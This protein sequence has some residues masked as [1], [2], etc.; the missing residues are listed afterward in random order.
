MTTSSRRRRRAAARFGSPSCSRPGRTRSSSTASCSRAGPA[1]PGRRCREARRRGCR[2]PR[3]RAPRAPRS[4]TARRRRP[5]ARRATSTSPWSRSRTPERIRTFAGERGWGHLRLL[6]SRNNTY[7]RDYNAETPDGEQAPIL[8]VFVRD[9]DE[10]RHSW[11]SEL[12]FAPRDGGRG[13]AARR[14]DLAGLERPRRDPWRPRHPLHH[15]LAD[16]HFGGARTVGG[17]SPTPIAR[18]S[19]VLGLEISQRPPS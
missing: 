17:M 19:A 16:D 15:H 5:L 11:A 4:S 2:S 3:P 12:L 9:G 7:N 14:L 8:N 13:P 10:F 6:S 1:T 18:Y